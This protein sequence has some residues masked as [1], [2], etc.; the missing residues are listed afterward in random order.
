MLKSFF[1]LYS[2]ETYVILTVISLENYM[3]KFIAICNKVSPKGLYIPTD[4]DC[5]KEI[6]FHLYRY[7]PCFKNLRFFY[8]SKIRHGNLNLSSG[9]LEQV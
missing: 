8:K 6:D 9:K 5:G 4:F 1:A 2:G 3:C 7:L